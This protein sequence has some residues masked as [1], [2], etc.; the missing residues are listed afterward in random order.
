MS[1]TNTHTFN[2]FKSRSHSL[3]AAFG[4]LTQGV[5]MSELLLPVLRRLEGVLPPGTLPPHNDSERL[6]SAVVCFLQ[7]EYSMVDCKNT[8]VATSSG[9]KLIADVGGLHPKR[10]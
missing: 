8:L 10:A 9:T 6:L 4:R 1:H 2:A 5:E 7:P 3:L